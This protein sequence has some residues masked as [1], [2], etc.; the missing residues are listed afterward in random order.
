MNEIDVLAPLRR[1]IGSAELSRILGVS[2]RRVRQLVAEG[3]LDRREGGGFDLVEGVWA[4][5]AF[6]RGDREPDLAALVR[7]EVA[8]ALK[9][10]QP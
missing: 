1:E 10:R 8:R 3:I 9:A 5:I 4:Y 2:D 6:M 7:R